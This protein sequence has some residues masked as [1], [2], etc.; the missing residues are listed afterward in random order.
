M[1]EV[2]INIEEIQ[3]LIDSREW[4]NLRHKLEEMDANAIARLIEDIPRQGDDAI[5]FRLLPRE[6]AKDT[7]QL[8]E[9]DKQEELV[10]GLADRKHMLAELLNDLDPDDR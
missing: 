3:E 9:Y 2:M 8:L 7:F 6:L 5:I 10:E 1:E 4:K